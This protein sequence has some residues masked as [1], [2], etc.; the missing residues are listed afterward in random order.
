MYQDKVPMHI[1][2]DP[3]WVSADVHWTSAGSYGGS[4]VNLPKYPQD[5]MLEMRTLAKALGHLPPKLQLT[6]VSQQP[7]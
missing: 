3:H 5:Q 6:Q 7:P 4:K 1:W 2:S